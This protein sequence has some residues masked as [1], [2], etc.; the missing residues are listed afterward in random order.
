MASYRLRPISH[1]TEFNGIEYRGVVKTPL[2]WFWRGL[3]PMRFGIAFIALLLFLSFLTAPVSAQPIPFPHQFYGDV[4]I[5]GQ[6]APVGTVVSTKVNG[7]ESGNVTTWELGAYGW[8]RP[9]APEYDYQANLLVQGEHISSGDTIEFYINNFKADQTAAFDSGEI[10]EM[11]LTVAYAPPIT[12][13]PSPTPTATPT[14]TPT[15]TPT[16]IVTPTPTPTATPTPDGDGL[17]GG[18]VAG[19]AVGALI[20]GAFIAWLILRRRGEGA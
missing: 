8:G 10:T 18:A 3:S 2:Y 9:G 17:S 13:T 11:D 20:A 5:G 1:K 19:I 14:V 12:P 6:P 7:V 4:A 15:V 16:P